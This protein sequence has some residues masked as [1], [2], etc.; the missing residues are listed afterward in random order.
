MGDMHGTAPGVAGP[1]VVLDL[2]RGIEVKRSSQA[3]RATVPSASLSRGGARGR[4]RPPAPSPARSTSR[5]RWRRSALRRP[6][7]APPR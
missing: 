4:P 1:G 5:R 2:G 6:T 7:R 3:C